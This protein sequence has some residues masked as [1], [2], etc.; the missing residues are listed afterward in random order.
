MSLFVSSALLLTVNN[1]SPGGIDYTRYELGWHKIFIRTRC[2]G[3]ASS[4]C[5]I[6]RNFSALILFRI[7]IFSCATGARYQSVIL[8]GKIGYTKFVVELKI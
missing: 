3:G 4:T 2:N 7:S 5:A 1:K 6:R 8:P